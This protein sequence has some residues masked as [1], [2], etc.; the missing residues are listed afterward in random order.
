MNKKRGSKRKG[1]AYLGGSAII[2]QQ[3][4]RSGIPRFLGVRLES[5]S[6]SKKS[7]KEILK[8]GGILDPNR[9]GTGASK[10][11]NDTEYITKSKN[12]VHL[13]GKHKNHKIE[14]E[15]VI[16][17]SMDGTVLSSTPAYRYET[18]TPIRDVIYRKSQRGLYRGIAGETLD[19]KSVRGTSKTASSILGGWVGTKGK[20]LYV[21][22]S[23]KYFNK[24]FIPDTDD[25]GL[26][27]SKRIKV[28]SNRAKA[29]LAALKQEGDGSRLKGVVKLIKAN[30]KRALSGATILAIGSIASAKLGQAGYKNLVTNDRKVKSH[31]RKNKTGKWSNVKSFIRDKL[32]K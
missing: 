17:K 28:Y 4:I 1:V 23:D 21:G 18:N 29:T 10:A 32:N 16:R 9:G 6:T 5:H 20:T 27:S 12:Y 26:K 3:A 25:I 14:A 2:G 24:N 30:P 8:N 13:T 7:A 31:V 19:I 11:V 22:G 15:R